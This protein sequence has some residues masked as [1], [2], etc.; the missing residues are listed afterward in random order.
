MVVNLLDR[1]AFPGAGVLSV[2]D[3]E[4]LALIRRASKGTPEFTEIV[5]TCRARGNQ[6]R[7]LLELR[8][9]ILDL[10]LVAADRARGPGGAAHAAEQILEF[11][12]GLIRR[13]DN[14][15]LSSQSL[16]IRLR[17]Q[18]THP[19]R[20]SMVDGTGQLRTEGVDLSTLT[21][22]GAG[23]RSTKTIWRF[24]HIVPDRIEHRGEWSSS[25]CRNGQ[26]E[27]AIPVGSGRNEQAVGQLVLP[28]GAQ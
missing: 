17:G 12:I 8:S 13:D 7:S 23:V 22:H 14:E 5:Q 15:K 16:K 20:C 1:P 18:C 3:V 10:G 28:A 24:R 4:E 21:L 25:G 6:R 27:E 11:V 26:R 9:Q 19:E 2:D